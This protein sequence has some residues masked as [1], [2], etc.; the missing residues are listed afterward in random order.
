M[1]VTDV[2]DNLG[3]L[4]GKPF[5]ADEVIEAFGDF[6]ESGETEVMVVDSYSEGYSYNAYINAPGSTEFLIST[7]ER[8]VVTGVSVMVNVTESYR[9]DDTGMYSWCAVCDVWCDELDDEDK[10]LIGCD[11][12]CRGCESEEKI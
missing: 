10:G 2:T 5:D 11:G 12:N 6:E 9:G 8:N 4:V 3:E 7:D 1:T